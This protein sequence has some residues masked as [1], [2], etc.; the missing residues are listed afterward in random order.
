MGG[1]LVSGEVQVLDAQNESIDV[2]SGG[3]NSRKP[4]RNRIWVWSLGLVVIMLVFWIIRCEYNYPAHTEIQREFQSFSPPPKAQ[5]VQANDVFRSTGGLAGAYYTT[6]MT[7]A[8]VRQHYE[9]QLV[10]K[11]YKFR[12]FKSMQSWGHDYGEQV[13]HYCKANTMVEIYN[14]GSVP[15][16]KEYQFSFSVSGN[17]F[18]CR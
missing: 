7:F 18:E 5:S 2:L 17:A 10:D 8:D 3:A 9:R 16:Q 11:E 14:P 1:L 4:G 12:E 13:L 15:R 6:S